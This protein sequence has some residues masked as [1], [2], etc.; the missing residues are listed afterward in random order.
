MTMKVFSVTLA[1]V[2]AAMLMLAPRSEA[3]ATSK[4]TASIARP[5]T[6]AITGFD[7]ITIAKA[8]SVTTDTVKKTAA[9]KPKSAFLSMAPTV[10]IQNY[11]PEDSGGINVVEAPHA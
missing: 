1:A 11:R 4:M 9:I 7:D 8:E 6:T 5:E 10:E 2:S 3:Q